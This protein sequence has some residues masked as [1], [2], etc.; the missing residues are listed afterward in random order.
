MLFASEGARR[1]VPANIMNLHVCVNV[2]YVDGAAENGR[3]VRCFLSMCASL[4]SEEK[5]GN[6][7]QPQYA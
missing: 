6:E 2:V 7:L 3:V 4:P 5:P 1:P